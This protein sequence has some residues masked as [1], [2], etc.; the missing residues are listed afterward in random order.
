M[1]VWDDG[2]ISRA[3]YVEE[4]SLMKETPTVSAK[5]TKTN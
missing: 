5:Q 3:G 1:Y 4:V 2:V